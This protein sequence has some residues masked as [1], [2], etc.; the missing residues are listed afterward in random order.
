MFNYAFREYYYIIII[1]KLDLEIKE[2]ISY[3]VNFKVE[4]IF[5]NY[6]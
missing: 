4:I 5:I 1:L 3:C 6:I 2:F